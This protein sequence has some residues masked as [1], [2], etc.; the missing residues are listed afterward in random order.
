MR[1]AK[2]IPV[3]ELGKAALLLDAVGG[4]AQIDPFVLHGPPQALDKD[5]VV[6]APASVHADLDPVIPQHLGK[7]VAGELRALISIED[8]GGYVT[9]TPTRFWLLFVDANRKAPAAPALTD[10]EAIAM[11]K[12]QVAWTGKYTTAD[13]TAE[14]IKLTAHVDA[15][16]SQ[17]IF[18]TD[19]VY[20]IRVNGNKMMVKSPG[21]IVP[22]TG[23][24]SVVEFELAKAD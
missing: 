7:L 21:V 8:A 24:T 14:G 11:M 2:I 15:A 23:Q 19:R 16:S 9:I 5:I 3:K 1:T 18:D 12:T 17:A 6:A 13:Q 22:M 20:F 10:A 4:W